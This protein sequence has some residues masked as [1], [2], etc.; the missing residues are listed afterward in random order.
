M[1]VTFTA[2]LSRYPRGFVILIGFLAPLFS[3]P[4][5]RLAHVVIL[6]SRPRLPAP[7]GRPSGAQAFTSRSSGFCPPRC[8]LR[9]IGPESSAT[10]RGSATLCS[11]PVGGSPFTGR[12]YGPIGN[13]QV[14]S[15][16]A[17]RGKTHHLLV[18]RPAPVRFGMSDIGTRLVSSARPPRRAHLAGSLFATYTISA[19]CFLR[20]SH[21]WRCPCHVGVVLP[22]DTVD[23]QSGD[24][25]HARH[26]RDSSLCF[27]MT[28][29]LSEL[30][31]AHRGRIRAI[32]RAGQVG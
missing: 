18:C 1:L 22:S 15:G 3:H 16:R 27:G 23:F 28:S 31:H 25:C 26:T 13:L 29:S 19:S 10:N 2:S 14:H 7:G 12:L 20:T 17:S 4:L 32:R 30:A 6:A 11:F 21:Y 9:F 24:V 5:F 8:Y